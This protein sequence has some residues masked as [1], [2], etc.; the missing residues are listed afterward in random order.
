MAKSWIKKHK[1]PIKKW[2][3]NNVIAFFIGGLISL[4]VSVSATALLSSNSIEYKDGESVDTA[5]NEL[6][7]KADEIRYGEMNKIGCNKC[8]KLEYLESNG[9]QYIDTGFKP[10]QNTG[11]DVEFMTL[12][13]SGNEAAVFGSRS[14]SGSNELQLNFYNGGIFGYGNRR[15]N[16][17]LTKDLKTHVTFLNSL[18]ISNGV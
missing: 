8:T 13:N 10:N 5:V 14:G 9:T 7:E 3:K 15:Y 12:N 2:I 4:V 6:Y 1:H 18:Y 17:G 11:F 16:V